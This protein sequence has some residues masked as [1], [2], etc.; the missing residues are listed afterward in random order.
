M[1]PAIWRICCELKDLVRREE[2]QDLV[3]YALVIALVSIVAV[4][5]L[6]TLATK[7]TSV[8]TAIAGDL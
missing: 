3:E 5:S 2:G 8:F 7:I 4:S 1:R 6:H